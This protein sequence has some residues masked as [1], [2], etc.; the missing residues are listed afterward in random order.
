MIKFPTNIISTKRNEEENVQDDGI[1]LFY[2]NTPYSQY[3]L[4][5]RDQLPPLIKID[6]KNK[7]GVKRYILANSESGDYRYYYYC[8]APEGF[9]KCNAAKIKVYFNTD[10]DFPEF[11]KSGD[12]GPKCQTPVTESIDKMVKQSLN[13]PTPYLH[14]HGTE[15]SKILGSFPSR[16]LITKYDHTLPIDNDR[17]ALMW[18]FLSDS[19]DKVN[20]DGGDYDEIVSSINTPLEELKNPR[21]AYFIYT[22]STSLSNDTIEAIAICRLLL[23]G[24]HEVLNPIHMNNGITNSIKYDFYTMSKHMQTKYQNTLDAFDKE[25]EKTPDYMD[26]KYTGVFNEVVNERFIYVKHLVSTGSYFGVT[27]LDRVY[28]MRR[29]VKAKIILESLPTSS[30]LYKN[31]GFTEMT[32]K[33]P[34]LKVTKLFLHDKGLT[35]FIK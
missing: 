34:E 10:K 16:L 32:M 3:S 15:I 18:K 2:F 31:E 26:D 24:K 12:H 22:L 35:W 14:P 7:T 25:K 17:K 27:L 6:H 5:L 21:S 29:D 13:I 9:N 4:K 23:E 20:I 30:S 11:I 28:A 8:T 33:S 19:I 1:P